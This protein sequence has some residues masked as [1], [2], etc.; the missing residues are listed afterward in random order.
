MS[1]AG[2]IIRKLSKPFESILKHNKKVE[3]RE[4]FTRNFFRNFRFALYSVIPA[5][6]SGYGIY[7]LSKFSKRY[8]RSMNAAVE[9]IKV[10]NYK[11]A[12]SLFEEVTKE[13]G[14]SSQLE[15]IVMGLHERNL[16]PESAENYYHFHNGKD[17]AGDANLGLFQISIG[18]FSTSLEK[19]TATDGRDFYVIGSNDGELYFFDKNKNLRTV[20]SKNI[21]GKMVSVDVEDHTCL[22][23]GSSDGIIYEA[24]LIGLGR[25]KNPVMNSLGKRETVTYVPF[26]RTI[27]DAGEKIS[28][29][30]GYHLDDIPEI[31]FETKSGKVVG[32]DRQ[33]KVL[34]YKPRGKDQ[35][36]EKLIPPTL[37]RLGEDV[38]LLTYRDGSLVIDK[39]DNSKPETVRL[40]GD[41]MNEIIV[42]DINGD[43]KQDILVMTDEN[44][45]VVYRQTDGKWGNVNPHVLNAFS[46]R[47]YPD[48][49]WALRDIDGDNIDDLLYDNKEEFLVL[50]GGVVPFSIVHKVL[51]HTGIVSYFQ[52][53]PFIININGRQCVAVGSDEGVFAIL[54][55][56]IDKPIFRLKLKDSEFYG[57]RT[58]FGDFNG[59]KYLAF[60]TKDRVYMIGYSW[61]KDL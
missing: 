13:K 39:F 56:F 54:N 23:V 61:L 52:T 57:D 44:F 42:G 9:H 37:T 34:F 25:N 14:K 5:I 47:E 20:L 29:I 30:R 11:T 17:N 28:E 45:Y 3:R 4:E 12:K 26:V 49:R 15:A 46:K 19:I 43:K 1:V 50:S 21:N 24:S 7:E 59:Q 6:M 51:E 22:I 33:G 16:N 48:Y 38:F 60:A 55:P 58:F 35:E 2:S 40:D 8:D 32:I 53:Q 41:I 27:Y 31:Y 18:E 36:L 10:G